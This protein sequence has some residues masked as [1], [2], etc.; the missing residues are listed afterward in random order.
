MVPVIQCVMSS[1]NELKKHRILEH[2]ELSFFKSAAAVLF[3]WAGIV[4]V[5]VL[6]IRFPN[7]LVFV[8]GF[9]LVARQQH[10]LLVLVHDST[11]R[12]LFK[13]GWLNDSVSHFLLASPLCMSLHSYRYMHLIHHRNPLSQGDPDLPLNGGYPITR[14]SFRRKLL[15]DFFGLTYLKT[16]RYFLYSPPSEGKKVPWWLKHTLIYSA[17]WN[18]GI[19]AALWPHW[20]IYLGLWVLPQITLL[21]VFLRLRGISEHSGLQENPDQRHSSRSVVNFWQNLFLSPHHVQYHVEHHIF[22]SVPFYHLKHLHRDFQANSLI[23]ARN[24]ST[25]YLE[26]FREL[27]SKQN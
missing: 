26:L 5:W 8:L 2:H 25:N 21:Q 17:L 20:G 27:S 15:R 22:P 16:I 18:A 19:L 12:R 1:A 24:L 11:H 3:D 14:A 4:G 6:A 7:P 23:P 10:A 9:L 13:S